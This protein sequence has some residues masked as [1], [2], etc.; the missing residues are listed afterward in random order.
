M[1]G[2]SAAGGREFDVVVWGASGFTGRLVVEYLAERYPQPDDLRW[3]VG[4][5]SREKLERVLSSV[6]VSGTFPEILIADSH[7]ASSL[8]TL[9]R[10][11]RVV[12]TTVGPYAKHGSEMVAA[13][14]AAGTHYCDLS[15]E[16]QWIR[17]M[18]D[19]HDAAAREQGA[20]ILMSCGF[21]SV[22]SDIGVHCLQKSA[23][24]IYGEPCTEITMLVR[25]MKGGASGGTVASMINLIDEARR[26]RSVARTLRDP[27]SLNPA[28][29]RDGPDED[30]GDRVTFDNEAGAW[31]GPFV[32]AAINTRTVR[33][34]NALLGYPYGR[35]FR[36]REATWTG[37][38]LKGCVRARLGA[39]ALRTFVTIAAVPALRRI[40]LVPFLPGPGEGPTRGARESGYFNLLMIGRLANGKVVRLRIRGDRDPGYGSTCKMLAETAACLAK[41]DV[42]TGG[43]LWTP[44][45][46]LGDLLLSRLVRNAG[47]TFELE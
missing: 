46:A 18:I 10:R 9:A 22:P 16:P 37:P 41:D 42:A 3:A 4:G 7:D 31:T 21:D 40:L 13:C 30:G 39:A 6:S 8:E 20:R 19:Q 23:R 17:R 36:Y 33:R 29:E 32:M 1:S 35:D 5:R 28:G 25:A 44:A 47:L 27:Y 14:V 45:A 43:G 24:T 11:T 26:D 2:T 38:G 12:L 15:G 34:T